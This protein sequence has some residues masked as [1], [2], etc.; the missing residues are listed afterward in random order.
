[1]TPHLISNKKQEPV[2]K[3]SGPHFIEEEL[4][5]DYGTLVNRIRSA[6]N[7]LL[8]RILLSLLILRMH[9]DIAKGNRRRNL[10]L[11]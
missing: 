1:M 8:R 5:I 4:S 9:S 11:V 2:T 3:V 10:H 6:L 7:V